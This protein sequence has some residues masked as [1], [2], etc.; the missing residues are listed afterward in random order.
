MLRKARRQVLERLP[1]PMI[2]TLV[3]ARHGELAWQQ[4]MQQL[5]RPGGATP[6]YLDT[7]INRH[8]VLARVVAGYDAHAVGGQIRDAIS[9]ALETAGVPHV[10][11]PGLA[12]SRERIAVS[13]ADR[14]RAL[15]ALADGLPG[16]EW[17]VDLASGPAARVPAAATHARP[18]ARPP[19]AATRARTVR[20]YPVLA[21]ASGEVVGAADVACELDLWHRLD[22]AGTPR[23][24]GGTHP[25]G[26]ML[27]PGPGVV[28][29]LSP[30]GWAAATG[31]DRHWPTD[32]AVPFLFDVS[33]P[34]DIVYTWVDGEDPAWLARKSGHPEAL[35]RGEQVAR[36]TSRDELRYSLRSV[37]MYASWVR[38]I[39]LV[40][41]RQVPSWLNTEHPQLS[42][43]DHTEIFTDPGVLP[44][45][46]SH[47]IESQLH[48]IDGLAEQYLYLNDDVFLGRPVP[49]E[50]FFFGNGMSKFFPSRAVL[51]VDPPRAGEVAVMSAAKQN[52]ALLEARFGATITT[53]MRHTPHPQLRSV[54]AE[55]ERAYPS[56]FARVAAS[57][58]RQP[59]DLSITSAL[60]HYYAYGTGRAVPATINYLYHDIGRPETQRRL[61]NL[62]RTRHAD[63]FCLNDHD[64]P[65]EAVT[66]QRQILN[67][68]FQ[69][70]F[71]LPSPFERD[72]GQD[73][74]NSEAP[75]K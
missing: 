28:G 37:A 60:H 31:A 42:V 71:P 4:R 5:A 58:F 6:G 21:A 51:D 18:L 34:V 19:A 3:R 74:S 55:L 14:M 53:K 20:V 39:Y 47:A 12:G 9:T 68:F 41:D 46:N 59:D 67:S 45:Y 25:A 64:S 13:S 65:P 17:V 33:E 63:A 72:A 36:Y 15:A 8:G 73:F 75:G 52:R 56:E 35:D 66:A 57:R 29:Y 16:A 22:V 44:V 23:R 1:E 69:A 61:Q 30:D 62:L 27:A 32:R 7:P 11:V 50:L 54:L 10:R 70:Y 26:T 48:H 38:H 40:T 24:D 49:P 2:D 43:V